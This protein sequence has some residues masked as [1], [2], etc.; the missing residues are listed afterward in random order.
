V[1]PRIRDATGSNL[2]PMLFLAACLSLAAL[3]V[4]VIERRWPR[5]AAAEGEPTRGISS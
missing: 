2:A 1:V 4:L 5:D 3:L